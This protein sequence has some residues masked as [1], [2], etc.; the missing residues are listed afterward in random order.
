MAYFNEDFLDFFKELAPNN[1]K[2]WFD[3]NRKRYHE[4]VKTPFDNFV[5]ALINETKKINPEINIQSK[6]A[7]FRINRDIRF[8]KDKTPYKLNRSAIISPGGKKDKTSPGL[9]FE[10]S[11]EHVRVYTG[12]YMLDKHQLQSVREEIADNLPKFKKIISNKKF[13]EIYEEVRG[14][15]N[16]RIPKEFVEVGEKQPLIY[17][18]NYY[19]YATLPPETILREDLVQV[20]TDTYKVAEPF[21]NFFKRPLGV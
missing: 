2:D 1:S 6:D 5:S 16:V 18:K 7:V 9:Y 20:I 10:F 13:K 12:V 21:G 4:S 19:V 8:S 17:N 3:E 14:E 11:P 15:K